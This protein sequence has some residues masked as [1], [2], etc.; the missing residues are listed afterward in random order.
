M[1]ELGATLSR[2]GIRLDKSF[3]QHL[4]V[5]A[6]ALRRI[7]AAAEIQ[8]GERVLEIG[9]GAGGLTL[10]LCAAGAHVEA[11][12][13]DRRWA[14]VLAERL[15]GQDVAITWGDALKVDLPPAAKLVANL[16]Y[17]VA[18]PILGRVLPMRYGLYVVALQL[19][20]AARAVAR[21]GDR[22]HG[23]LSLF[24]AYHGAAELLFRLPPGAFL[25]PPRVHS[26]IVRIRPH[27]AP[28]VDVPPEQLFAVIRRAFSHR[29]KT[30]A[31]ALGVAAARVAACGLDP[32][33]RPETLSLHD[34]AVLVRSGVY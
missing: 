17:N 6:A 26:A 29:R 18:G 21:P 33:A 23:S 19:E 31:N 2:H 5:D 16:P 10:A 20:V 11:V 4:L 25:P 9:P 22:R 27:A 1:S 15:A 12:E 34:F 24:I 8:P 30:I 13:L 7:V 32:L 3:G 28:P 14:G